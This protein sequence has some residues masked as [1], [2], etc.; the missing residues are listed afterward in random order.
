M[1]WS[2]QERYRIEVDNAKGQTVRFSLWSQASSFEPVAFLPITGYRFR[3]KLSK[4]GFGALNTDVT[5]DLTDTEGGAFAAIFSENTRQEWGLRITVDGDEFFWGFPDFQQLRRD[6]F[7]QGRP[8]LRIKFYNPLQYAQNVR[9]YSDQ[10]QTQLSDFDGTQ[11]TEV[12]NDYILFTR[13]FREVAFKNFFDT[14]TLYTT[15]NWE[16]QVIRFTPA[17][18]PDADVLLNELFFNTQFLPDED[19]SVADAVTLISR[20]FNFRIGWSIDRQGIAFW[21][22]NTG[23]N[24]FDTQGS[25]AINRVLDTSF[26]VDSGRVLIYDADQQASAAK[27]PVIEESKITRTRPPSESEEAPYSSITYEEPTDDIFTADNPDSD[28]NAPLYEDFEGRPIPFDGDQASTGGDQL[29]RITQSGTDAVLSQ[30]NRFA[31]PD[32]DTFDDGVPLSMA[33]LNRINAIAHL[34]WRQFTR[35][36]LRFSYD[37]FLDPMRNHATDFDNNVYILYEGEYDLIRAE[38]LVNKSISI[39]ADPQLS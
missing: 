34:V 14:D 37:G 38:T 22:M 24:D 16:S 31:D 25:F 35:Q 26:N 6:K 2:G 30:P 13:F 27:H 10:I 18:M 17:S 39:Y 3:F 4:F 5:I 12:P 32:Q 19:G 28:I 21:K 23:R 9:Y 15:H 20:A 33:K 1:S 8:K 7:K 36:N 11:G 29:L